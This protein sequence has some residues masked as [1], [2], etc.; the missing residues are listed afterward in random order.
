M[1]AILKTVDLNGS[2]GSHFFLRVYCESVTQHRN[3]KKSTVRLAI[4]VGSKDAYSGSGSACSCYINGVYVGSFSSIASY[5]DTII[6]GLNVDYAHDDNGECLANYSVSATI[7]WSGLTSTSL[8]GTLELPKIWDNITGVSKRISN[9]HKDTNWGLKR[10]YFKENGVWKPSK[11]F[12]K[13][14]GS[15]YN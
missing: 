11:V 10:F 5:S 12:Y 8:S 7:N 14:D 1:A 2:N 9:Y 15:W 6:A 3:P 13:K 4:S